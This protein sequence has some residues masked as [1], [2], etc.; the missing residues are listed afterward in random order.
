MTEPITEENFPVWLKNQLR[1]KHYSQ[2]DF[3]RMLGVNKA[4]VSL[5]CTGAQ[6]PHKSTMKQIWELLSDS[7]EVA[8]VYDPDGILPMY[9]RLDDGMKRAVRRILLLP[10]DM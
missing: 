3:A 7:P 10:D 2:L 9:Y 4:T 6:K 1:V 8:K 5:W